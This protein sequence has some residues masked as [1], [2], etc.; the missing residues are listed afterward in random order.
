MKIWIVKNNIYFLKFILL[1]KYH[2]HKKK[3]VN[4]DQIVHIL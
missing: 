2:M 1:G 4:V 3:W